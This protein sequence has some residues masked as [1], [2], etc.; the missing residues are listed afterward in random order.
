MVL[1]TSIFADKAQV[2]GFVERFYVTVLD[3]NSEESGLNYWTNGLLSGKEAGADIARGFIFSGEFTNQATTNN[4]FLNV[5]YRAFFNREPDDAGLKA[6]IDYL[7]RG[8]GRDFILNGFLYSQEFYNLCAEYGIEPTERNPNKDYVPVDDNTTVTPV[9]NNTTVTPIKDSTITLKIKKTGQTLSYIDFDDGYYQ[10]G[11][12]PSYTRNSA[13][14]TVTDNLRGLMWQDNLEAKT[15][16]KPW[17]TEEQAKICEA[18]IQNCN[19]TSGDTATTYCSDLTIGEYED[20]R[21]PTVKELL[22]VADFTGSN[23]NFNNNSDYS[24]ISSSK[25]IDYSTLYISNV[26][27][28]NYM[29]ASKSYSYVSN[30]NAVRCVRDISTNTKLS[31]DFTRGAT[32]GIVTDNNT[33][34]QWQDASIN[35]NGVDANTAIEYCESFEL[36]GYDDWRLPNINEIQTIYDFKNRSLFNVFENIT[37]N[38]GLITS[39]KAG[40]NNGNYIYEYY[41]SIYG[42]YYATSSVICVRN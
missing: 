39:T 36:S 10:K 4:E 16:T 20:W 8:R 28:F 25:Y 24:Y 11:V 3:R 21:L 19:D 22:D 26:T 7:D 2:E 17:L 12:E 37:I 42:V 33:G 15:V 18:N 5:L 13:I 9:E 40:I 1:T 35:Q 30:L 29:G 27:L 23:S 32:T 14:D 6:W 31:N 41:N 38:N 34:L